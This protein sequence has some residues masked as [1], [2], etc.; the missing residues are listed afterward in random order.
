[1]IKFRADTKDTSIVGFGLSFR[2]LDLL[3]EGNPIRIDMR[4]LGL[5][6]TV[7]IFAGLDEKTMQRQMAAF[8]GPDTAVRGAKTDD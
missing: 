1:M 2:N 5:E 6:G 7:F 4:E 8:V 3:R